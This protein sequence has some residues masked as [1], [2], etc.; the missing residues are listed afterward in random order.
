M[1]T[2]D[3]GRTISE[4]IEFTS[5][6]VGLLYGAYAR[7]HRFSGCSRTFMKC[8]VVGL[9]DKP[10]APKPCAARSAG[11]EGELKKSEAETAICHL[12]YQWAKAALIRIQRI[13]PQ[14]QA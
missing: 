10:A 3:F 7:H 2:A 13:N 11:A 4:E 14:R 12:C 6:D 5:L 1:K 9:K 8:A